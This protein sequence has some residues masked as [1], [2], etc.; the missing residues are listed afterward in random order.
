VPLDS[1]HL[2]THTVQFYVDHGDNS[3]VLG[4]SAPGPTGPRYFPLYGSTYRGL[5]GITLEVYAPQ[6]RDQMW[7]RSSS[8]DHEALARYRVGADR[9]MTVVYPRARPTGGDGL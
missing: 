2:G 4:F 6:P 1:V 7:V 3:A 5:P 8:K 9:C